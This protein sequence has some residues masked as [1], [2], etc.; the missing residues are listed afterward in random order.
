METGKTYRGIEPV[1]GRERQREWVRGEREVVLVER[2][3]G[4]SCFDR[5]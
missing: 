3:N 1:G 2:G 5:W 4:V